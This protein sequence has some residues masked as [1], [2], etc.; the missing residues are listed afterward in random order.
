VQ[1]GSLANIQQRFETQKKN[2]IIFESML[3]DEQK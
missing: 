1:A 2:E 3:E